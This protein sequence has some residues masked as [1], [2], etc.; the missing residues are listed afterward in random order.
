MTTTNS[1]APPQNQTSMQPVYLIQGNTDI[2]DDEIDLRELWDSIWQGKLIIAVTTLLFAM[3]SIYYALSQPNF[4]KAEALLVPSS[5]EGQGGLGAMAAKFG[6]LASLA[7]VKLGGGELDKATI[8]I[9]V[10]KS[11]EFTD[12]FITK[13]QLEPLV[14]AVTDWDKQ[15]DKVQYDSKLYDLKTN[16]WVREVDK[17]SGETPAPSSWELYETFKN[18]M[19][20]EQDKSTNL[21]TIS[22]EYY[23]P[24]IA[25]QWVKLLTEEI[26]LKLRDRDI[27]EA[28]ENIAFLKKQIS[29]TSITEMQSIF[30]NLIEEQ[31]KTLM[32]ANA[33]REYA[34]KTITQAKIPEIKSK[35][36][37]SVICIVGTVV[38]FMFSLMIVYARYLFRSMRKK[39]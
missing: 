32:L 37:R 31:T 18:Y 29:Q 6:G 5:A 22:V 30:Y 39:A 2:A 16:T 36:R 21:I 23:S 28:N 20:V 38:G 4:Y 9:E 7:G 13:Y 27:K 19:H 35:P 33:S 25:A 8:A 14:F 1:N 10:L 15:N 3:G 12:A 24:S 34:L 11:W 26:N 17:N